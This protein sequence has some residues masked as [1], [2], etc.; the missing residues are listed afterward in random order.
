MVTVTESLCVVKVT[1]I[2]CSEGDWQMHTIY[3]CMLSVVP[4]SDTHCY[5][6]SSQLSCVAML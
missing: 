3:I 2:M 4:C 1:G 6:S 5:F